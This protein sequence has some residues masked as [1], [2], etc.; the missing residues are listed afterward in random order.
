[1]YID[2]FLLFDHVYG[3][4]KLVYQPSQQIITATFGPT[5]LLYLTGFGGGGSPSINVD[6]RT[7]LLHYLDGV[8][9]Q[10]KI[11]VGLGLLYFFQ[12]Y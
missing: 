1:M 3:I 4:Y 10:E 11:I 12:I 7:S 6:I 8:N 9:L 2:I 5:V